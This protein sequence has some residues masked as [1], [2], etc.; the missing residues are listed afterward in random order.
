MELKNRALSY[1]PS[2]LIV[3]ISLKISHTQNQLRLKQHRR[4]FAGIGRRRLLL[5]LEKAPEG[6]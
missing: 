1:N 5:L 4:D 6:A 2:C 3:P